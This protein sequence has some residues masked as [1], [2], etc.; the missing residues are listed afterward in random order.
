M[1]S[2]TP[3]S[4]K[5]PLPSLRWLWRQAAIAFVLSLAAN[6]AV[7]FWARPRLP[8]FEPLR[9]P[10]VVVWSVGSVCIATLWY[11]YVVKSS[12]NPPRAFLMI[13]MIVLLVS[14]VPNIVFFWVSPGPVL[15]TPTPGGIFT[16][17]FMHVVA[18]AC[19]LPPL[20]WRPSAAW[21]IATPA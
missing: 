16:L 10:N 11:W 18:A 15:G 7:L 21:A 12:R 5:G 17:M 6:L 8:Y 1:S 4:P 3:K 9:V 13:S 2:N 20:L 19:I 14:F